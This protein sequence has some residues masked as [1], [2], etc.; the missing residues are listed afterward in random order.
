[1]IDLYDKVCAFCDQVRILLH[2]T[3]ATTQNPNVSVA[4]FTTVSPFLLCVDPYFS[5]SS[6]MFRESLKHISFCKQPYFQSKYPLGM[7]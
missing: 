5:T 3:D 6:V 1:V 4:E 2:G 7:R